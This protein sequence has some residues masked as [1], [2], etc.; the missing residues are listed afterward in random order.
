MVRLRR[1]SCAGPG[2]TR[3]R[4]GRGFRYLDQHGDPLPPEDIARVKALVIPPAWTEVWICPAPNGHLQAVGVHVAGR[5]QYLYHL[6]NTPAVARASYVDPRVVDLYEDGVTIAAACRR[7]HRSP[8]Q[9][10]AAVE[11]AVRAMLARE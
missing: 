7:R 10:Q 8:A 3:R 5:R 4:S 11:R 2:W 9:R 1:V 6:G